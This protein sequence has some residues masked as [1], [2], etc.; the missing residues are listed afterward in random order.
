VRSGSTSARVALA[1]V[2][3]VAPLGACSGSG[4]S[5]RAS[6]TG[7]A[8]T[9]N[10][11]PL[12]ARS[13]ITTADLGP[14]LV[15]H[16]VAAGWGAIGARSCSVAKG[17]PLTRADHAYSGPI[18]ADPKGR[19]FVYS[20]SFVFKTAASAEQYGQF[21]ATTRFK[22][23]MRKEHQAALRTRNKKASV[24][25]T[26]TTFTDP[27]FHITSFYRELGRLPDKHGR[28]LLA[29]TYD[30]YTY[31]RGRVIVV[32]SVD[33]RAVTKARNQALNDDVRAA[34][35]AAVRALE[36]RVPSS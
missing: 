36:K 12:G 17:S 25:R 24:T 7:T 21:R 19:F 32:L 14:A 6:D 3:A 27:A 28:L 30:R 2:A 23:C 31:L 1:V 29:A 15:E 10:K 4:G 26:A 11:D 34:Y 20:R 33:M 8:V 9:L 16:K 18:A 5:D 35:D 22:A 13:A